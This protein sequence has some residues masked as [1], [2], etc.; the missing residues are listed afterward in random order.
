MAKLRLSIL[1]IK[2]IVVL[3]VDFLFL[4]TSEDFRENNTFNTALEPITFKNSYNSLVIFMSIIGLGF[5]AITK[6]QFLDR[7]PMV[8]I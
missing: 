7:N 8:F 6:N 4:L 2:N 1:S 3:N 5:F